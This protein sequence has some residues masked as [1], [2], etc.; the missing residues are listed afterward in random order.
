[1]S[2]KKPEKKKQFTVT[3]DRKRCKGCGICIAL[4]PTDVLEME[5]PEMK[6]RVARVEA[7]IG[8]LMC[9]MHCPD[10]AIV[11]APRE[12]ELGESMD[13]APLAAGQKRP[14]RQGTG[15]KT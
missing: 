2:E 11:S 13:E 1:M 10:F 9:E 14:S 5:H 12:S 4:C 6:C 8:C 7:C 15:S 3:V